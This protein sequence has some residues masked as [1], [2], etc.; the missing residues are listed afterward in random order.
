M[1]R[2]GM[3]SRIWESI[4]HLNRN[5]ARGA[6]HDSSHVR[7]VGRLRVDQDMMKP[8][9]EMHMIKEGGKS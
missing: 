7:L 8:E 3:T 1:C 6:D 9:L 4:G 2:M 5:H